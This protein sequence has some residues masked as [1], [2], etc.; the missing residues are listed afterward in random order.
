MTDRSENASHDDIDDEGS[1]A[2]YRQLW[3][4]DLDGV[5][6]LI[7]A[8][9]LSILRRGLPYLIAS[10]RNRNISKLR[11]DARRRELE[12]LEAQSFPVEQLDPADE[13]ERADLA[14][15][16]RRELAGLSPTELLVVW[17]RAEGY[18]YSEIKAEL[19][20]NGFDTYRDEAALRQYHKRTLEKLRANLV[21]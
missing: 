15:Q 9:G 19:L 3:E 17:R 14:D 21:R 16:L 7:A 1:M 13:A 2:V 18:R 12:Q 11:R 6:E 4:A 10:A 8:K 20:E 5:H